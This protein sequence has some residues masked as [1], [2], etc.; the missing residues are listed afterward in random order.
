MEHTIYLIVITIL[1]T[2]CKQNVSNETVTEEVKTEVAVTVDTN[3][4]INQPVVETTAPYNFEAHSDFQAFWT[5]FKKAVLANDREAVTKMTNFPFK[6][7]V[8]D[9][10][11]N[12][13]DIYGKPTE[14]AK[15][16]QSLTCSNKTAFLN[17]YDKIF[18]PATKTAIQADKY[19]GYEYDDIIG[20]DVINKGEYVLEIYIDARR[21]YNMAFKKSNGVF[22]LA[23]MPYYS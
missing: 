12:S 21:S 9:D 8:G 20:G 3:T 7:E 22:K 13:V 14:D 23:Y 1:F 5:D 6:D 4:Q 17:K 10:I 18:L 19:R 16:M 11:K 15:K 2:A